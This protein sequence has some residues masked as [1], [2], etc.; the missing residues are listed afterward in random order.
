MAKPDMRIR[1]YGGPAH[2]L[3]IDQSIG[4]RFDYES[5]DFH[6]QTPFALD[7]SDENVLLFDRDYDR[8]SYYV[9]WYHE[10]RGNMG[11]RMP[12]ALIEGT[13][14]TRNEDWDL[15]VEMEFI[16]WEPI[17]VPNFMTEFKRWW[18]VTLYNLTGNVELIQEELRER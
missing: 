16:R 14:L 7:F 6:R 3:L 5:R 17:R 10:R 13:K 11:R 15:R 1:C 18:N 9:N 8:V 12:I 2:G 4:H